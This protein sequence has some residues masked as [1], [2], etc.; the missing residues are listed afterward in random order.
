MS[1]VEEST[2][3]IQFIEEEMKSLD[4]IPSNQSE[5]AMLLAHWLENYAGRDVE[6]LTPFFIVW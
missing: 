2:P 5:E 1:P 4:E 6:R 3:S